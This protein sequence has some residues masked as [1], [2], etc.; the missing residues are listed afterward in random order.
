MS[1]ICKDCK[2]N[3]E[4]TS[5]EKMLKPLAFL[6]AA[7]TIAGTAWA[8]S[9]GYYGTDRSWIAIDTGAGPVAYNLDGTASPSF[10]GAD[11]GEIPAGGSLIIVSYD[12]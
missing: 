5:M 10:Q 3:P 7:T 12:T 8:D 11:L 9:W 6:I 1:Q 2:H 4:V